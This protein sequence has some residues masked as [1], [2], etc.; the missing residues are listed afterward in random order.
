MRESYTK[1]LTMLIRRVASNSILPAE[2]ESGEFF[3]L[4]LLYVGSVDFS[5]IVAKDRFSSPIQ[6]CTNGGL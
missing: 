5:K 3:G 6:N 4:Q 2:Y 1:D